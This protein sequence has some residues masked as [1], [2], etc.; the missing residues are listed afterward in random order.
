VQLIGQKLCIVFYRF[1]GFLEILGSHRAHQAS[2]N[3]AN[4]PTCLPV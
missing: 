2:R 4:W 1:N 3:S